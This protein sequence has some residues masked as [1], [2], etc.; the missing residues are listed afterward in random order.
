[1]AGGVLP[2]AVAE[3]LVVALA[4]AW[5]AVARDRRAWRL[6]LV[7]GLALGVGAGRAVV[8]VRAHESAMARA[9]VIPRTVRCAG[10]AVVDVS[11]VQ[12][13]GVLRWGGILRDA[14]CEGRSGRAASRCTAGPARSRAGTRST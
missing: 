6:V 3:V 2:F 14:E 10:R 7:G 4:L 11:P 1:V 9:S 13:R 8:A 12:V 5:L